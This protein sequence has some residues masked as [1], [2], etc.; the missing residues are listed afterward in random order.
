M[1][2]PLIAA[3]ALSL[4]PAVGF[5]AG[6]PG[7]GRWDV[8]VH[9]SA[10]PLP[11]AIEHESGNAM[12]AIM[13][14]P[15]LD[16]ICFKNADPKTL[17]AFTGDKSC[18]ATSVTLQDGKMTGEAKCTES[19]VRL[20]AT[21]TGAYSTDQ[22]DYSVIRVRGGFDRPGTV[23]AVISAKRSGPCQ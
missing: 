4:L 23:A 14:R 20:D 21:I 5:A 12:R 2:R 11:P 1:L 8:T 3:A 15:Y 9:P 7:A 6:S 16:Q 19:N 22:V 17:F 10:I 13:T 18:T